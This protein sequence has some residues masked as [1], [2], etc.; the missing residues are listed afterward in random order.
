MLLMSYSVGTDSTAPSGDKERLGPLLKVVQSNTLGK[1]VAQ[2]TFALDPAL[3]QQGKAFYTQDTSG[4]IT[5]TARTI[6]TSEFPS[7]IKKQWTFATIRQVMVYLF[8][9]GQRLPQKRGWRVQPP[10]TMVQGRGLSKPPP[11]VQ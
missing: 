4:K 2:Y 1:P 3:K 9:Y 11:M 10:P 5:G 6:A 7:D 8:L